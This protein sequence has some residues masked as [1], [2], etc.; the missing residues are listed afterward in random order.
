MLT[1]NEAFL[2]LKKDG[3]FIEERDR[4]YTQWYWHPIGLGHKI[5]ARW[6]LDGSGAPTLYREFHIEEPPVVRK[7]YV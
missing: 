6:N 7:H 3:A 5:M 2:R 4:V 1:P